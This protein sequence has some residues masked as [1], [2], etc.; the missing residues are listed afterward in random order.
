MLGGLCLAQSTT[1]VDQTSTGTAAIFSDRLEP[2]YNG[3]GNDPIAVVQS[4]T[5]TIGDDTKLNRGILKLTNIG[6]DNLL[7]IGR[8][9]WGVLNLTINSGGTFSD[10][11][12]QLTIVR[13]RVFA[14]KIINLVSGVYNNNNTSNFTVDD[15]GSN[16]KFKYLPIGQEYFL[17]LD[18]DQRVNKAWSGT[19][20][21]DISVLA[22]STADF[23]LFDNANLG[24]SVFAQQ[25]IYT[26]YLPNEYSASAGSAPKLDI[27]APEADVR[28]L[29][30]EVVVQ[31]IYN[32]NK[33][34]FGFG[35]DLPKDGQFEVAL[36]AT[37]SDTLTISKPSS[38]ISMG[39][40]E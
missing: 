18:F 1:T 28:A 3:T 11:Q 15:P 4:T 39:R 38:A 31:S 36:P 24:N 8:F 40:F 20:V 7:P 37:F 16:I 6:E 27:Y 19:A 21:N 32:G 10:W 35:T 9:K 12:A 34:S 5:S 30:G 22:T 14:P 2:D 25:P 26:P 17:F 29:A 23:T 13:F 33:G